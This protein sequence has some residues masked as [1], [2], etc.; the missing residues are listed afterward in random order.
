MSH[1]RIEAVVGVKFNFDE[2]DENDDDDGSEDDNDDDEDGS[3]YVVAGGEGWNSV[4]LSACGWCWCV[5][6]FFICDSM[7]TKGQRDGFFWG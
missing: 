2:N 3:G 4:D 6:F 1:F 5:S 7:V